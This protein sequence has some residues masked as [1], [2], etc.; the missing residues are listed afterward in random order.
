[1]RTAVVLAVLVVPGLVAAEEGMWT[2]DR[3]PS[4]KVKAKYGFSPDARWLEH[5]RLASARTR[6]C[7]A[8]FVSPSGLVITNNHCA[9]ECA[10]DLST[11]G[12][13]LVKDGFV[14]R[15][16]E[17]ELRCP[18]EH[19]DQ[20]V[21]ITDVTERIGKATRGKTGEALAAAVSAETGAIQKA[22]QVDARTYC[23]VVSLYRGGLYHLY[24]YR[25]WSD[26]RL[27]FL[28]EYAIAQ[29]GGDPDNYEYPRWGFDVSFLR[30]YEDGKPAT[31]PEYFRWS[32]T[33]ASEGDLV[34]M[35][36]DPGKTLRLLT[37]A[38]LRYQRDVVIPEWGLRLSELRGYL[39][40]FRQ[41]GPEQARI[42]LDALESVE[43][44]LKRAKGQ[45]RVLSDP[46]FMADKERAEKTL[47]ARASADPRQKE[48][49]R[50]WDEIERATNEYLGF[51]SEFR[52]LEDQGELT[53]P[54]DEK[55]WGFD[56]RLFV[57]ARELVRGRT[58]RKLPSEQRLRE[59]QDAS[60]PALTSDLFSTAPVHAELET[61]TL[62]WS[63]SKMREELR[64]EHPV[65][66]KLLS[67]ETPEELAARVVGGTKLGDPA[68]RKRLWED[69]AALD[70]AMSS[71]PMLQLAA[72]V[73]AESRA[74]RKR[75]EVVDATLKSN[76]E[77]IA[78]VR[79]DVF[80]TAVYPDA[81]FTPRLSYGTVRGYQLPGRAIPWRTE[82]AGL[83]TRATGRPPFELP[84]AWLAAK[85]K[86]PDTLPYDV[87]GTPDSV[88]GNSGSPVVDRKG[89]LVALNF[90]QNS[91]GTATPFGYDESRRRAVFVH[92][93]LILRALE[94][95]YRAQRIVDEIRPR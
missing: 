12:R 56:S 41:R 42:A 2:F 7:S 86:L 37:M 59:F 67:R 58:E 35:S 53:N 84:P 24:R 60:L 20:L 55:P 3:F 85:G 8:G 47:R 33:G 26:V 4:A 19:V 43:N 90:D 17:D 34:F 81:T 93:E 15:N 88:G 5:V 64:P 70:A 51:R 36:G 63:L 82:L 21:E 91:F 13:D 79:F 6:H 54:V 57:A 92:T 87:V 62:G 30:V 50:A 31:T 78:R 83:W 75:Y 94:T 9:S 40:G 65:V 28:P 45:W 39:Q 1:V 95:V 76:G 72:S 27:V 18:R 61:A 80:G 52:Y 68:V 69:D 74:V 89:E 25:R 22:C 16:G 48:R 73:D 66:Q 29:F 23:Q 38:Q 71:D 32:R 14:A 77:L 11:S 49:S 46:K 44:N 10:G